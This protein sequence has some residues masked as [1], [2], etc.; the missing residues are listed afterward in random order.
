MVS[1]VRCP[2]THQPYRGTVTSV[3][4][5]QTCTKTKT[6]AYQTCTKTKT[7]AYRHNKTKT[8]L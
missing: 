6:N 5:N 7:N 1:G 4:T 2:N 8:A 3:N